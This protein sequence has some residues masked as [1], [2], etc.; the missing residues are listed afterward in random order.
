MPKMQGVVDNLRR[1]TTS[2]KRGK[3]H[4]GR[5]SEKDDRSDHVGLLRSQSVM[6]RTSMVSTKSEMSM[7]RG[8]MAVGEEK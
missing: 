1:S 3:H 6:S 5:D 4:N 8:I 2:A 7:G